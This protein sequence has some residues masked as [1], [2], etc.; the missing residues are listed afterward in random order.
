MPKNEFWKA[1]TTV[2]PERIFKTPEALSIAC[3]EY[4]Q[5]A[6]DNPLFEMRPFAYQGTVVQD[7]VPLVRAMTITGLC[8]Y[9]GTVR[10]NWYKMKEERADL[11]DIMEQVEHIIYDQKFTA[12]S[13][14]L[15][16][17]N[18]IA[19]DLGLA[20][21]TDI[22]SAGKQIVNEYHIHPVTTIKGK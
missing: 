1:R 5:W 7:A 14:N 22:T 8:I 4:F 9:L 13:A 10:S 11:V 15:L 2:P 19:R 12:A 16:N 20:D 17:A 6:G 18:I 3:F 21:K